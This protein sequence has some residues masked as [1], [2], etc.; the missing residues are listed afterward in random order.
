MPT[1]TAAIG[2]FLI[3]AAYWVAGATP[4]QAAWAGGTVIVGTTTVAEVVGT[5]ALTSL[6]IGLSAALTQIPKPSIQK[7]N[8]KTPVTPRRRGYGII[9]VGGSVIMLRRS[10]VSEDGVLYLGVAVHSGEIDSFIEHWIGDQITRLSTPT[11]IGT[12]SGIFGVTFPAIPDGD[13]PPASEV[14]I[15]AYDPGYTAETVTANYEIGGVPTTLDAISVGVEGGAF[16]A[17]VFPLISSDGLKPVATSVT[18]TIS[19]GGTGAS[20]RAALNGA[21]LW[22]GGA[23]LIILN[24]GTGY[25]D[26]VGGYGAAIH[27]R[28]NGAGLWDGGSTPD[29]VTLDRNGV[30]YSA[31]VIV[32]TWTDLSMVVHTL[33]ATSS[34]IGVDATDSRYANVIYPGVWLDNNRVTLNY[35]LGTTTQE[36]DPLLMEAFP[37][38]WTDRHRLKGIA[39]A[40]LKLK[41]VSLDVFSEV[42][43]SGVP[44]YTATI[45]ASKVWDPR[46]EAQSADDPSTWTWTDNAALVIMDYLWHADGMRLDR[47]MIVEAIDDWIAAAD[48]ADEQMLLLSGETEARYRLWVSYEFTDLP[49]AVLG[50]MLGCVDGRLRLREDG[51]I[52]LDLGQFDCPTSCETIRDED[53]LSYEGLLRGSHKT[54]LKNEIRATYLS[55]GH[56]YIEQEAD[57]LRDED[58]ILVDGLQSMNLELTYCP[59]HAQ[60]RRRMKIESYRQ[61]PEWQGTI[62]TNAKGLR[63]LGKRYARFVIT[64][65]GINETFFIKRSNIDLQ[66][67]ICM[68]NVISFPAEAY[69]WD[70]IEEGV[71]PENETPGDHGIAIPPGATS[72]RMEA[73]GGGGG[74]SQDGRGGGG[75]GAKVVKTVALVPADE[76]SILQFHVGRRG[77]GEV[78]FDFNLSQDGEASTITGTLTAG[79]ISISAGGGKDNHGGTPGAGGVATG[80]DTNVN[81]NNKDSDQGGFSASGAIENEFPGGG[82]HCKTD[83]GHGQVTFEFTI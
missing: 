52:V 7:I 71:S 40:V 31:P 64:D 26:T 56:N 67:G 34:T 50:R 33:A 17:V 43:K 6:S 46:D 2:Q 12:L 3:N 21:G 24:A 28:P 68:F 1:T 27:A 23:D 80:G 44:N 76:G 66:K 70:P 53:I 35:Y 83:G 25:M 77:D 51:A 81:G 37:G 61:N 60:A 30:G 19:G 39:Y 63:L 36:A 75:G 69:C 73:V 18:F 5:V 72:L 57:P 16:V 79:A 45:K 14:V 22:D 58:S 78:Y 47:A 11:D 48:Y 29:N 82:G 13:K 9:R 20:F 65:C 74:G 49:K 41:G 32:A 42:Y 10:I 15:T 54:A 59:S 62:Y 4:G 38:L 55:P 8:A